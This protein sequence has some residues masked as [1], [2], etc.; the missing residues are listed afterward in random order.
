MSPAAN[1]HLVTCL[2]LQADEGFW[3]GDH[4]AEGKLRD[5]VTGHHHFIEFKGKE[6][7]RV[8]NYVRL[9]VTGDK[10]WI[11]PAGF[12]ERRFAVL[13]VAPHHKQDHAYFAAIDDE[14]NNGGRE[15]LLHHLLNFDL[16]QVNLRA[17]PKTVALLEQKISSLTAEA[18]WLLDLLAR[19][20]LP[21]GCDWSRWCPSKRLIDDYIAHAS[22]RGAR[23][24]AI[25]TSIGMFL[26]KHVPGLIKKEG[27]YNVWTGEEPKSVSGYVYEFP[28]L[29]ECRANFAKLLNQ[30]L[31][32]NDRQ[33]WELTPQPGVEIDSEGRPARPF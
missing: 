13:D 33:E 14:M 9:F 4:S 12:D 10:D 17:I 24:R 28:P 5:L 23:R 25:E 18:G 20:E 30:D 15:A 11:V 29:S 1:S 3:A 32:W 21:W 2:L 16:S 7:I 19:G 22:K 27:I 31:L 8:Q 6:P 26:F